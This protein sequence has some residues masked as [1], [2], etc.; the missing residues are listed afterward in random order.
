MAPFI[1]R[2]RIEEEFIIVRSQTAR[3]KK[4]ECGFGV[5]IIAGELLPGYLVSLHPVDL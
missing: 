4:G 2:C 5:G 3:N 1:N